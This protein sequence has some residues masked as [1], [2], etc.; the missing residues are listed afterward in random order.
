MLSKYEWARMNHIWRVNSTCFFERVAQESFR[1]QNCSIRGRCERRAVFGNSQWYTE[2]GVYVCW[3]SFLG[4]SR[5][6]AFLPKRR[7]TCQDIYSKPLSSSWAP[8]PHF[9]SFGVYFRAV[10]CIHFP[11]HGPWLSSPDYALEVSPNIQR[12]QHGRYVGPWLLI[13]C[14]WAWN[15]RVQA[16][17]VKTHEG[18]R[19]QV[20]TRLPKHGAG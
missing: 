15:A 20:S 18:R 9:H 6:W 7:W 1:T 3:A 17:V 4:A 14:P 5:W 2:R 16:A 12:I 11:S 13:C 19:H 10:R 8:E